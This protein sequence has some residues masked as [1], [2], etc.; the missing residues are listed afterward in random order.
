MMNAR[1]SDLCVQSGFG[2]VIR[3]TRT[4]VSTGRERTGQENMCILLQY[5]LLK[6]VDRPVLATRTR[7]MTGNSFCSLVYYKPCAGGAGGSPN[8]GVK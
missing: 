6:C 8:E 4:N 1:V 7:T 3:I 5:E 2:C